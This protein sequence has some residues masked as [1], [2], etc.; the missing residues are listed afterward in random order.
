MVHFRF[1]EADR[2]TRGFTATLQGDADDYVGTLKAIVRALAVQTENHRLPD[3]DN[4]YLFTLLENLLPAPG[5]L[6]PRTDE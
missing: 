3:E 5:Q 1:T 2:A 6:V 4:Y